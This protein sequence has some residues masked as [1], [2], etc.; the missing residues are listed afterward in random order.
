MKIVD[1]SVNVKLRYFGEY[2]KEIRRFGVYKLLL[3]LL[4]K[5]IYGIRGS[6]SSDN[7]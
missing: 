5:P 4:I 1:T 6:L 7:V 2:E 3:M